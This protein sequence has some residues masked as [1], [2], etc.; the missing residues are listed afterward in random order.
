MPSEPG[1]AVLFTDAARS[2]H[3]GFGGFSTEIHPNGVKVMPMLEGAWPSKYLE[4]L[5]TNEISM[6][7]G[8][9]FG[10]ACLAVALTEF[11]PGSITHMIC[12]T[13]STGAKSAINSGGSG[14]PPARCDCGMAPLKNREDPNLGD[15]STREKEPCCGLY[16]PRPEIRHPQGS[17]AERLRRSRPALA[18]RVIRLTPSCRL[19]PSKEVTLL[20]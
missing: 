19:I 3:T 11:A 10:L 16:Q 7:A 6:P 18:P 13:D 5:R 4:M 12:F 8:E 15:P 1:C 17:R 2:Y 9:L 20:H 14:A